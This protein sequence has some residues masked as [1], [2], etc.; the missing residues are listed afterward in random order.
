MRASGHFEVELTPQA[1]ERAPAGR[2]TIDKKYRGGL[3]GTGLGQMI[4]KRTEKGAA[5][6]CAIEEVTGSVDGREGSFTLV[7]HG[8]MSANGQS[9]D[10]SILEGSGS[11]ELASITGSMTITQ[12]P[13]GHSYELTYEL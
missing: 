5:A 12:G 3:S 2:M 11:G 4:S 7:H 8:H 1:D 13:D 10:I 6:Y 9:L